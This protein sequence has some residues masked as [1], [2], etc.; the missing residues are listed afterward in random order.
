MVKFAK[1]LEGSL[2]PEWKDAY[3]NYKEL[4]RD[5]RR[6]KE[7]RLLQ[8]HGAG[9]RVLYSRRGSLSQLHHL[10]V[11]LKRTAHGMNPLHHEHDRVPPTSPV[12]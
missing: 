7:D 4:K 9:E 5:V 1:Q 10:G 2:V 8:V 12:F 11:H 6:I 3:C